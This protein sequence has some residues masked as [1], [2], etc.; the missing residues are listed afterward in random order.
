MRKSNLLILLCCA[1]LFVLFVPS[2]SAKVVLE[3]S[4]SSSTD[5]LVE[6]DGR[7]FDGEL[8]AD[9]PNLN[10]WLGNVG[11]YNVDTSTTG[12]VT[13]SIPTWTYPNAGYAYRS[14]FGAGN[15]AG[16]PAA[17]TYK[18]G[19]WMEIT[20]DYQFTVC[21]GDTYTIQVAW[22]GIDKDQS[23][24]VCRPDDVGW[25]ATYIQSDPEAGNFT[26][27]LN[28]TN[29][30]WADALELSGSDVGLDASKGDF[31][32][33]PLR[34]FWQATNLDGTNWDRTAF[35]VKNL[36]SGITYAETPT[37]VTSVNM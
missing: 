31:T 22:V 16:V 26:G 32:S 17:G 29:W 24:W 25:I 7:Y 10:R 14:V 1:T 15:Q 12:N 4:F 35:T 2:A 27:G 28:F 3:T 6:P 34:I 11:W 30:G 20:M 9:P 21:Y 36:T 33:D 19:D 13:S 5:P 37:A 8:I 18:A 23:D